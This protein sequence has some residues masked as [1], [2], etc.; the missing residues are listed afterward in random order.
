MVRDAHLENPDLFD[1]GQ[2]SQPDQNYPCGNHPFP[3]NQFSK[4]LVSGDKDQ[5]FRI[6]PIQHFF[7]HQPRFGLDNTPDRIP[8]GAKGLRQRL[9]DA[10]IDK[11]ADHAV[12]RTG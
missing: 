4:I 10:F 6:G 2:P 11:K 1:H 5:P 3:K 7:V 9:V 8:Q 12:F